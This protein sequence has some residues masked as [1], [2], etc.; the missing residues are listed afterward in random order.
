[1]QTE[2]SL[3]CDPE[4]FLWKNGTFVSAD[5]LFPGTKAEP[6]P[7]EKGAVQVDGL[8]LEFNIEPAKT[9][10][11]FDRNIQTVLNQLGEMVHKVDKDMHLVFRPIANFTS[12]N[13]NKFSET[14]K[15]LGCDPDYNIKGDINPNPSEKLANTPIRTAAGH[16]HIGW[17]QGKERGD[18][19]HFS[20]CC[21]ISEQFHR[22]KIF[23]PKI[24]DEF[25]RLQYYGANGAFRPKPYGI[26]LRSPSNVWVPDST[27]RRA[28]FT[29]TV[30]HFREVTGL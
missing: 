6:H 30:S 10:E 16:V 27:S 26:E 25:T 2:I 24:A 1:M 19:M 17:T 20:D 22:A 28:V 29:Q 9:E 8:A 21:F 14:S 11:E 4:I 23:A 5:G 18:A 7:L 12:E 13:W 15:V 3:G